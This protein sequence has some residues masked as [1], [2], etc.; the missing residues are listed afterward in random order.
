MEALD[1]VGA[2]V[3]GLFVALK[4]QV[5]EHVGAQLIL[6]TMNLHGDVG[7]NERAG[8]QAQQKQCGPGL[9]GGS[10]L[11]HQIRAI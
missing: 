7:A 10:A 2:Q 9:Q 4:A 3:S 11:R 8:D 6:D 1:G 5:G